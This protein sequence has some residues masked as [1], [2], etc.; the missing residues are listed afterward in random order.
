MNLKAIGTKA[1]RELIKMFWKTNSWIAI[2]AAGSGCSRYPSP[3][4]LAGNILRKLAIECKTT[5]SKNNIYIPKEEIEQLE[6]FS[7]RFGAEPWLG[8]RFKEKEWYFLS[9]E[10]TKQTSKNHCISTTLAKQK[11]LLFEELIA[12]FKN[13]NTQEINNGSSFSI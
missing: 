4:I 5:R 12:T 8:I 6:E 2:R 10:D 7:S 9:L 13:N 1:E 3:D 11:G